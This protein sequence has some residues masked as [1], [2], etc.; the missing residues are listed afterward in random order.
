MGG[1]GEVVGREGRE[2]MEGSF[3]VMKFPQM[4]MNAFTNPG[5]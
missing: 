4:D 5:D 2:E 1:E 3:L